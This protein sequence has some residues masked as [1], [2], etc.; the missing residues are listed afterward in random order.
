[1]RIRITHN[2]RREI[3]AAIDAAQV[4]CETGLVTVDQLLACIDDAEAKI[5]EILVKKHWRGVRLELNPAYIPGTTADVES[6]H[7][8]IERVPKSGWVITYIW[9]DALRNHRITWPNALA[10]SE[11]LFDSIERGRFWGQKG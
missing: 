5:L 11:E 10:F 3:Q 6:T 9:R 8:E 2:N 4:D 7:F 1:M